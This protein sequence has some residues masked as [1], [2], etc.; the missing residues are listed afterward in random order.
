MASPPTPPKTNAP[1]E[2]R[3]WRPRPAGAALAD[4]TKSTFRKRGFARRE[5]LTQWPSIV[6]DLM[7]RYSCPERLQFGRDRSEGATLV[8]RAS[9]GFA[10]ELQHLHPVV[11]DRINT[12]FG[13]QAVA[14]LSIV[15]GPLPTP[16]LSE[17]RQLRALTAEEEDRIAEQVGG[18]RNGDLAD[19]LRN[20]GRTVTVF[21]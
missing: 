11:L 9:S 8:V 13:Y 18:T 20:L 10:T 2:R 14:R 1:K 21:R 17:R 12:F 19:A 5:I 3:S 7:A 6:G 16:T 15:Q 4:V